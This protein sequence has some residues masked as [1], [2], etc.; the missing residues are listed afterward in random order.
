MTASS[1]IH[2]LNMRRTIGETTLP[3]PFVA[4][5]TGEPGNFLATRRSYGARSRL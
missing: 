3:D 2:F 1:S 4:M 5:C